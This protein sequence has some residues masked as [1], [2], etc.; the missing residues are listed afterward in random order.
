MIIGLSSLYGDTFYYKKK[1]RVPLTKVKEP[2]VLKSSRNSNPI[3]Y[4]KNRAGT[5]IGV[6]DK[7]IVAFDDTDI[8][9]YVEREYGLEFIEGLF[10]DLYLYRV[11]K[12][13]DALN[14]ANKI[15][16]LQ[17]IRYAHPDF[18]IPKR[19]RSNDPL[20]WRSWHLRN[21]DVQNAWYLTKGKDRNG[22]SIIVGV[23]DEGI[24]L[25]HEDL[26]ANI[27][28]YGNYSNGSKSITL[29][30]GNYSLLDNNLP[31]APKP[32]SDNW[33]GTACAGLIAATMD[34]Y[35]G[36][37]GIA[38]QAKI[39]AIRYSRDSISNDIKAYKDMAYAGVSII[40]N[41]WGT[42]NL[43][44]DFEEVL[45]ELA[46]DGRNGKGVL[47]FFAAGNDG[48]NMDQYYS[49]DP[50]DGHV[51]CQSSSRYSPINDESESPYVISI[52]A[53]DRYDHIAP[54]SNYGSHIDFT[55]PGG[56]YNNSIIT[57][58]KSG[59]QGFSTTNYTTSTAGFSGTSA[60]A[61]IAAGIAALVLSANPTLSREEVIEILRVT[62]QKKG[63]YRYDRY[64]RNDHWGYGLLDAGKAVTLAKNYGKISVGNFAHTIYKAMH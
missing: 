51:V 12:G 13:K 2:L 26:R 1:K 41:S 10:K 31:N 58:D 50:F 57:T 52:A 16:E 40:S 62:A 18:I 54:Y 21:I 61:P 28:G 45:K 33:H 7:I 30:N 35:L 19:T 60:A 46:I 43:T 44:E 48:C 25:K 8:A 29:V 32:N 15:A 36:S 49:I 20:Y 27:Y 17:G 4:Y 39:L 56:G 9:G 5:K 14:I 63:R 24:D 59:Y 6:G 42:N 55:A 37:T 34:N 3:T 11:K 47:I 22:K 23:Y 64:G 53:S 38:P